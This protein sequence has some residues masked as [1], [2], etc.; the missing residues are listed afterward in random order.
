[1]YKIEIE[2]NVTHQKYTYDNVEDKN[3]GKKLFYNFNID[4]SNLDDG[5]YTLSLYDGNKLITS[6]L[7]KIGDFNNKSIQYSKGNNIYIDAKPEVD[8]NKI[9]VA[10]EGIKLAYSTFSKVPSYYDFSNVTDM[11]YM[12]ANCNE[13]KK[14][15][16]LD[17]SK[18]NNMSYMFYN[19]KTY[20]FKTIPQ[21]DTGNVT[22]MSYMFTGCFGFQSIPLLNTSKVTNMSHMFRG[23][24]FLFTIPQFDTGNVT[25]MSNMFGECSRI[26]NIPL[27]NTSNVTNMNSMF[28]DCDNLTTIP[29]LDTSNVEK[30]GDMFG[31]SSNLQSIPLLDFGKV[32]YMNSF[33]GIYN[34]YTLTYLG[35]FKDLKISVTSEFLDKAPNLTVESLMN[36]INN[37]YDLTGNG[38][39]GQSLKF[40]K[41]NLDKLTAEQIAVATAKGWT[42]KA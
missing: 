39:S 32:N 15:P 29:Q 22:D 3:N 17:T 18:V 21:F 19:C 33:F 12:F 30:V 1:M 26:N 28:R 9:D 23:C 38:L 25:D 40:G 2:N 16:L 10:N 8:I 7:L 42:L 41:T 14:V 37:I 11:S 13:L 6:E 20:T 4:T 24:S 31:Y 27:L 36:V 34:I 5:E 35:G